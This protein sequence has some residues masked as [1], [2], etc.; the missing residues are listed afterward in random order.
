ME[1]RARNRESEQRVLAE[2]RGVLRLEA[3]DVLAHVVALDHHRS[4]RAL[5]RLRVPQQR[6]RRE[7]AALKR[8][9]DVRVTNVVA[10]ELDELADVGLVPQRRAGDLGRSGPAAAA[11]RDDARV[12]VRRLLAPLRE[13]ARVARVREPEPREQRAQLLLARLC[14]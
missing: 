10:L 5:E 11:A 8:R 2:G 4:E 1:T 6:I 9:G 3:R 12:V 13:L 7:L 14:A